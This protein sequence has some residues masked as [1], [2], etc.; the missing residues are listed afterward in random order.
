MEFT[1]IKMAEL[2]AVLDK[3]PKAIVEEVN[4]TREAWLDNKARKKEHRISDVEYIKYRHET[5]L[6]IDGFTYAL[7]LYGAITSA[8]ARVLRRYMRGNKTDKEVQG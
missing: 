5:G 2:D 7:E 3:L 6:V 1:P 4:D 8:E